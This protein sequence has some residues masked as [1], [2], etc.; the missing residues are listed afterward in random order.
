MSGV[1][2]CG[3]QGSPQGSSAKELKRVRYV[4]RLQ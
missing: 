1:A 4:I 2:W 3:V